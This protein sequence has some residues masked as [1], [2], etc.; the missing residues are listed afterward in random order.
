MFFKAGP[1]FDIKICRMKKQNDEARKPGGMSKIYYVF[2]LFM[3]IFY[4]GMAYIMIFSPI[5]VERLSD[6]QRYGMGAIFILYGIFR[7]YR[8]SK[9]R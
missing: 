7:A 1:V 5:F 2:G 3:I 4:V 9:D 8:Q 6:P